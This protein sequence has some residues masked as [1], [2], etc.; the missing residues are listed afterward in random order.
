MCPYGTTKNLFVVSGQNLAHTCVTLTGKVSWTL[1]ISTTIA[2]AK[3]QK[4]VK[5]YIKI[6]MH[7]TCIFDWAE[8]YQASIWPHLK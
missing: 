4:S 1:E 3:L 7:N 8:I 2:M 5:A 6:D